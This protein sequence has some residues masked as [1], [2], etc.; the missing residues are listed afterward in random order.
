M[1]PTAPDDEFLDDSDSPVEAPTANEVIHIRGKVI[2]VDLVECHEVCFKLTDETIEALLDYHDKVH[3]TNL[4]TS[5]ITY[6]DIEAHLEKAKNEY[7]RAIHAFVF[8]TKKEC[9]QEIE[10]DGWG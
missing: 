1:L 9:L 2:Y 7:H 5:G 3:C 6:N 4:K 10:D 8:R